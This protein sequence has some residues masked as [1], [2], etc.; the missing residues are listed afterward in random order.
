[1]TNECL[2]KHS[3]VLLFQISYCGIIN[4]K[5]HIAQYELGAMNVSKEVQGACCTL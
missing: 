1:M 3:I 2:W 5:L 4:I